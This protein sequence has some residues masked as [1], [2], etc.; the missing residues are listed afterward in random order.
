MKNPRLNRGMFQSIGKHARFCGEL[1]PVRFLRE[2]PRKSASPEKVFTEESFPGF[3]HPAQEPARSPLKK[4]HAV[5]AQNANILYVPAEFENQTAAE[6]EMNE[7]LPDSMP[8]VFFI[9]A[10]FMQKFA[11]RPENMASDGRSDGTEPR[12]YKLKGTS[13]MRSENG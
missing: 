12:L 1:C 5:K 11:A 4:L 8:D 7:A 6:F 13:N 10:N 2:R 9:K 3:L